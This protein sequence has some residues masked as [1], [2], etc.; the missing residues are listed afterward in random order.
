MAEPGRFRRLR[1]RPFRGDVWV[2]LDDIP[3]CSFPD[4][5]AGRGRTFQPHQRAFVG[6]ASGSARLGEDGDLR[7]RQCAHDS[8]LVSR[9]PRVEGSPRSTRRTGDHGDI[10]L[11]AASSVCRDPTCRRGD[12]HPVADSCDAAHVAGSRR[13]VLAPRPSRGTRDGGDIRGSVHGLQERRAGS[14]ARFQE[15]A[16]RTPTERGLGCIW[17]GKRIGAGRVGFG[18]RRG[19]M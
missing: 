2:P 8:R 5:G 4:E 6:Y 10:R 1:S 3:A 12:A 9:F 17:C 7:G 13:C 11:H 19:R 16:P 14:G 18:T 15:G